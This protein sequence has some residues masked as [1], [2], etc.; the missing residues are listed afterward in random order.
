MNTL[1]L[2]LNILLA[3]YY[4]NDGVPAN[5]ETHSSV[6]STF[7]ASCPGSNAV[8]HSI[9][10]DFLTKPYWSSERTEANTGNLSVS[11]ITLLTDSGDGNTCTSFNTIYQEALD[12]E[13]GLGEQAHNVTYYKAGSFYFVVITPRQSDEPNYITIGVS[14]IDVYNQNLDL[15]KGYAF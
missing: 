7:T 11:Q 1:T 2:I 9:V 10:E 6:E 8:N 12:E 13:N 3:F 14:Y 5:H 4:I 15:I